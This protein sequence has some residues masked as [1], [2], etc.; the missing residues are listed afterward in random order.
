MTQ[1]QIEA[2]KK[3]LEQSSVQNS[4]NSV[5]QELE[6]ALELNQNFFLGNNVDH[7]QN[8]SKIIPKKTIKKRWEKSGK[9][10]GPTKVKS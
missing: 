2:R 3:E 6:K 5:V 7:K 9:N 8:N 1:Q 4:L 10:Y